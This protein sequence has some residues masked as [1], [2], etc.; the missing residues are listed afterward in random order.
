MALSH[1]KPKVFFK[2]MTGIR[3]IVRSYYL[4]KIVKIAHLH[5][6]LVTVKIIEPEAQKIISDLI[7]HILRARLRHYGSDPLNNG[8]IFNQ[9]LNMPCHRRYPHRTFNCPL[10]VYT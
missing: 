3:R 1:F 9:P 6:C 7:S 5:Q 2:H 8:I 10:S 4:P